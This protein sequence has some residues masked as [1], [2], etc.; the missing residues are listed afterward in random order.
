MYGLMFLHFTG[1]ETKRIGRKYDKRISN[2]KLR[3]HVCV[4]NPA[5]SSRQPHIE[6]EVE[7]LTKQLSQPCAGKFTG[8][9]EAKQEDAKQRKDAEERQQLG[10]KTDELYK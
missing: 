3:K 7:F 4:L 1:D 10:T 8:K 9:Q 6:I 5:I 2:T